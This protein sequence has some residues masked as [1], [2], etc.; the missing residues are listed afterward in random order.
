MD[1]PIRSVS[2]IKEQVNNEDEYDKLLKLGKLKEAGI[3]T[4]EEFNTEKKKILN[5]E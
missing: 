2:L 4:E 1:I 5:D 3:L